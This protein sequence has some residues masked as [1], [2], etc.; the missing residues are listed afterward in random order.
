LT[1]SEAQTF[2][3]QAEE[4]NHAVL[5][6]D[7]EEEDEGLGD[8]LAAVEQEGL[9][10]DGNIE[11]DPFEDLFGHQDEFLQNLNGSRVPSP[12]NVLWTSNTTTF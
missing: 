4:H 8:L 10:E 9:A 5:A 1:L 3:A 12:E 6:D 2:V 7:E 11:T